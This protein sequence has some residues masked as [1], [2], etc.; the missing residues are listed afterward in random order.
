MRLM[1]SMDIYMSE[2]MFNIMFRFSD[3]ED[4]GEIDTLEMQFQLYLSTLIPKNDDVTLRD[5]FFM[6]DE[7]NEHHVA[8][9]DKMSG[10]IIAKLY[11]DTVEEEAVRSPP[12]PTCVP[13]LRVVA[14]SPHMCTRV[15]RGNP[16]PPHVYLCCAW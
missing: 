8:R 12:R 15:A 1:R 9:I 10:F 5:C 7:R 6:E 14:L 11:D 13:V 3:P 2:A 4:G 16:E